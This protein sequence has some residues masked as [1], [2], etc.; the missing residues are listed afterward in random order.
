MKTEGKNLNRGRCLRGRNGQLGFI[1]E[2]RA[3]I[4]KKRMEEIM[5]EE[6]KWDQM[7]KV[8]RN[9]IVIAMHK[10]KSGKATGPCEVSVEMIVS[11]GKMGVSMMNC[12]GVHG[13][14]EECRSGKLV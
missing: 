5:N 9:A 2:D 1:E 12:V 7:E 10:M 6:N 13:M 3:K 14:V 11:S 4:R 8:A